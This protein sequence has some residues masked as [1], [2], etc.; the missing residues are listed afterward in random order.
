MSRVGSAPLQAPLP[1][2]APD[3][4]WCRRPRQHSSEPGPCA[5]HAW[6]RRDARLPRQAP[7]G[8]VAMP[9]PAQN[10]GTRSAHRPGE[11]HEP[12]TPAAG[13]SL[14]VRAPPRGSGTG[15]LGDQGCSFNTPLPRKRS[16]V[17]YLQTPA[18]SGDLMNQGW[19]PR[20]GG[21]GSEEGRGSQ[22]GGSSS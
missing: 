3:C 14:S 6:L 9:A 8:H 18:T 20:R 12:P 13:G 5:H 1:A 4:T 11:G 21:G 7:G 22:G 15:D 16:Q 19:G 2:N 10:S 17:Y